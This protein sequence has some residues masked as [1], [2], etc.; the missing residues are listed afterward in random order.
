MQ[1]EVIRAGVRSP[2]QAVFVV[3]PDYQRGQFSSLQCGLRAVPADAEG[4][5]FTPVDHPNVEA[6][7]VAELIAVRRADRDSSISGPPRPSGAVLP[8][9]DSGIS[10]VAARFAGAAVTRA[11]CERDP[12]HRCGRCRHSGRHRRS[13]SLPPAAGNRHETPDQARPEMVRGR[14]RAGAGRGNRCAVP[15]RRSFAERIR[16]GLE[17]ALGRRVEFGDVRFNLFTGPGFSISKV[18]IHEDPAFGREPFAYVESLEA[19]PRALAADC[20]PARVCFPAPRGCQRQSDARGIRSGRSLEFRRAAAPDEARRPAR[21]LC[22]IGP[23]QFQVRRHQIGL[24]RNRDRSRCLASATSSGG[25][26]RVHF[27]GQPARTD[28]RGRGFGNFTASGVMAA[29][30][31]S[32]ISIFNSSRAP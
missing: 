18:V 6:A 19:R 10:G 17:T 28:R 25:A 9:T 16:S 30:G 5:V 1:P 24:L 11:P 26:W 29:G 2:V 12:I 14:L 13:G 15:G 20:G 22:A 21:A 3:N 23:H 8:C 4:V 31:T 7:T 27:S 32:S